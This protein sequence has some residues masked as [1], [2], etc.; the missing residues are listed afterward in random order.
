M[1]Q[2]QH[3]ILLFSLALSCLLVGGGGVWFFLNRAHQQLLGNAGF[4][5]QQLDKFGNDAVKPTGR[6][7][8][9][10]RV[11]EAWEEKIG[12]TRAFYGQLVEVQLAKIS[13]EVSGLV[14]DLPIEVGMRVKG[15]E[16]LIA[17]TDRTW[18]E[19][20]LE[21]TEAEIHSLEAQYKFQSSELKR[22]EAAIPGTFTDS[23]IDNLKTIAEQ[24]HRNLEKAKIT[25]RETK[26]KLKRTTILAPF[27]GYV[28]KREVGL[29]ELLSPGT[30]IAEIVSLGDIDAR[31][32]VGEEFINQIK[33][34]D[35]IPIII[36][37]LGIQVIGKVRSVVPYAPTA[38]TSFPLLVRLDDKNGLLKVGM[39]VTALIQTTTPRDSVV[40]GKDA[41][42]D[43]PDGSTV[44]VVVKEGE[45]FVAKPVPVRIAV[46]A[47][48]VYGVSPET[49]EGRE[50][51]RAGSKTV[52]E[53]AERLFP[54]QIVR[55]VEINP[56]HLDNLPP[57][58]GQKVIPKDA[59][60]PKTEDADPIEEIIVPEVDHT[61]SK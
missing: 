59:D 53:G 22:R 61:V 29:G 56:V 45:E 21:Q 11:T 35:E 43:K 12:T 46:R 26:E 1:T 48:N 15:G 25:N 20:D 17:Q 39:S 41:V 10:I 31:I 4:L 55:I 36:D 8:S 7:P 42:L 52:I 2:K 47:P 5:Q 30:P 6:P 49:E 3:P 16:T 57:K 9:L 18:L 50:L 23:D 44:W 33:V 34:G 19:L 24:F 27:D 38:A 54:N 37:Q 14:V 58:T 40:V 32:G 28:V 51:L 60:E 13:S